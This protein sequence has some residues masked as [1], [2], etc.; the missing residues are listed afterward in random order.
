MPR[1]GLGWAG[2]GRVRCPWAPGSLESVY[3]YL[4]GDPHLLLQAASDQSDL[5][6]RVRHPALSLPITESSWISH[7]TSGDAGSSCVKW[8]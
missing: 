1:A 7:L 4:H 5:S 6:L 8:G 3:Q 2:W